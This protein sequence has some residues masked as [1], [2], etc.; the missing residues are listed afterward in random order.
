MGPLVGGGAFDCLAGGLYCLAFLGDVLSGELLKLMLMKLSPDPGTEWK[1][2]WSFLLF[3][4][5]AGEALTDRK[6]V[7][8]ATPALSWSGS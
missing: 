5:F 1:R 2:S 6:S 8:Q 3:S 4:L 7:R